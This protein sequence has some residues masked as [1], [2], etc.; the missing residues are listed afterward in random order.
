MIV[1]DVVDR[2]YRRTYVVVFSLTSR[3]APIC[4]SVRR[5]YRS[6]DAP[7]LARYK[8]YGKVATMTTALLLLLLLL[9][10]VPYHHHHHTCL[11]A[12]LQI[13]QP[14]NALFLFVI[15]VN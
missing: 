5:H 7:C 9:G 13:I 6:Q 15:V 12:H 10:V 11:L 4:S 14:T 3:S 1:R 2:S 8:K